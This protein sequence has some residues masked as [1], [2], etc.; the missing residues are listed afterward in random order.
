[1]SELDVIP[2]S[3]YDWITP[4]PEAFALTLREELVESFEQT[5]DAIEDIADVDPERADYAHALLDALAHALLSRAEL[6][7]YYQPDEPLAA[8]VPTAL[9]EQICR[10]H[11]A[12]A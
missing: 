4:D 9:I 11:R 12:P 3:V 1:M 6:D 10:Y 7:D 5:W 2:D 8:P